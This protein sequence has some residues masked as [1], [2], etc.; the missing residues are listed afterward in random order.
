MLYLEDSW[1]WSETDQNLGL[2]GKYRC[3]TPA[4]FLTVKCSMSFWGHLVYFR[5]FGFLTTL[6]LENDCP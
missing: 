1:S 5:L 6:S 4:Y 3:L 2:R